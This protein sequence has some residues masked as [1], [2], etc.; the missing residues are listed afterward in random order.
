[1]KICLTWVGPGQTSK[2]YI[3]LERLAREKH[4]SL[5]QKSINYDR[6]KLYRINP[7]GTYTIK[8]FTDEIIPAESQTYGSN[9]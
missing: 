1:M 3:R 7:S 4:S 2:Y 5:L 6:K 8:H 9:I